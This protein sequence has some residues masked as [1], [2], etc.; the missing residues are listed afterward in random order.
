MI[1]DSWSMAV[2]YSTKSK[3]CLAIGQKSESATD[4]DIM[5]NFAKFSV[6]YWGKQF[7]SAGFYN[8][9]QIADPKRWEINSRSWRYQTCAQVSYFNTAP[10]SG[11]LRA[12]SV[13]LEYHLKQCE[14]AFGKEMFPASDQINEKFGGNF[15]KAHNVF[16]SDFSDDPWQRA[17]VDFSPSSDQPY[18][19]SKCDDCG[20][21][22]DLHAPKA[23]DP[24]PL[25]QSRQEFERYLALWLAKGKTE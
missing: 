13:N 22:M 18:F 15:P 25:Q 4:E 12:Q 10:K 7:C 9:K 3:L 8:T 19:L 23:N 17:S 2:Q 21:C 1:A 24:L 6:E 14:Q 16:Y 5:T 11:S 20:H